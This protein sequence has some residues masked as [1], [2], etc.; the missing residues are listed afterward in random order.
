MH[1]YPSQNRHRESKN[2]N[3]GLQHAQGNTFRC[4]EDNE[5]H[6]RNKK[7]SLLRRARERCLNQGLLFATERKRDSL[8]QTEDSFLSSTSDFD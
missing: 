4:V 1:S 8:D 3:A 7:L 5:K 6:T 2:T